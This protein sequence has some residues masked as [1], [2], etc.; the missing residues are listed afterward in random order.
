MNQ[1]F[2]ARHWLFMASVAAFLN[3]VVWGCAVLMIFRF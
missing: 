1:S 3:V 2:T